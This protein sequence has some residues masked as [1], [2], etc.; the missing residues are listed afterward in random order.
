MRDFSFKISL[1]GSPQYSLLQ[2]LAKRTS[3]WNLTEQIL[4]Y[5]ENWDRQKP[6]AGIRKE[7][8]LIIKQIDPS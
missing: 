3:C 2:F 5:S 4:K 6:S 8:T 7:L 1:N